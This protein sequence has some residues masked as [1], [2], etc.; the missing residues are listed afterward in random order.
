MIRTYDEFAQELDRLG[1]M[2]FWSEKGY[3]SLGQLTDRAAWHTGIEDTDPWHWKDMMAERRD[4]AYAHILAGQG[5]FISREWYPVFNA[6]YSIDIEERYDMGLLPRLTMDMWRLF[7]E[8]PVWGR[9]ELRRAL[10]GRFSKKSEFESALRTLEGGMLITI[11]GQVQPLSLSGKP[12]GWQAMEYTRADV[13][14]S[15]WLE[16]AEQDADD[17]RQMIREHAF[18]NSPG[19]SEADFARCFGG[20]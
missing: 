5:T 1:F 4:G 18:K 13:Y 3:L 9:H 19:M 7:D 8:R 10:A 17:A 16:G 15:D 12:I 2:L 20:I 14:L 6:A 11:S